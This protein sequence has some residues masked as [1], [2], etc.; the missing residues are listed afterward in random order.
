MRAQRHVIKA[1]FDDRDHQLEILILL[2]VLPHLS[3][4]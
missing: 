4:D 1:I 3:Q 2:L